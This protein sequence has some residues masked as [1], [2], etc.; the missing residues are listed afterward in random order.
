M[1][2]YVLRPDL[3]PYEGQKVDKTSHFEFKGEDVEQKLK[4]LK[5]TTIKKSKGDR[6]ETES[7]MVLNLNEGDILLFENENRGWFLPA[8]PIGTIETA[9]KDLSGLAV[10]LDG[11]DYE[12]KEI[13]K[14]EE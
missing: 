8:E 2:Y 4:N 9:I 12:V 7:K 1:N 13:E 5:L 6:W 10:A 3:T 14:K 11:K